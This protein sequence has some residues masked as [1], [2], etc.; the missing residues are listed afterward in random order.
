[1]VFGLYIVVIYTPNTVGVQEEVIPCM[2]LEYWA[3]VCNKVGRQTVDAKPGAFSFL[4][5]SG[6][7]L[8]I[9]YRNRW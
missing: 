3:T 7:G 1:M 9:A 5:F 2:I 8:H 6:I 4:C